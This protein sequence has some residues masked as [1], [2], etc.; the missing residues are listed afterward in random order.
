M[1]I[2]AIS[3]RTSIWSSGTWPSAVM[4]FLYAVPFSFAYTTLTTGTGA[5]ILF[6]SVQITMIV[7]AL[8]SGERPHPLQWAGL[9]LALAGI[10]YLMLPGLAAPPITGAA[11]MTLAGVSWGIYTLLGRATKNA[12][13]QT[14]GNFVR[15]VPMVLVVSLFALPIF[16]V[17]TDGVL[18]AIASGA[19]ASGCGYVIWYAALRG[20]TIT[21]AAV[22]QLT[23]PILAAIGGLAFMAE[24]VSLRLII[25]TTI[26]LGGVGLALI[27]RERYADSPTTKR[28]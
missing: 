5:L 10:A 22:V 23:V 21:R 19:L 1:I 27:G 26:V 6:G 24:A 2:A 3:E 12:L 11:L 18:L 16:H 9:G 15:S 25:S 4:L 14:T 17:T 8:A 28:D 13:A 20:L 7:S